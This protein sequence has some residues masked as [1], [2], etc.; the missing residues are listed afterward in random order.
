MFTRWT[1]PKFGSHRSKSVTVASL[2]LVAFVCLTGAVTKTGSRMPRFLLPEIEK[3]G[4]LKAAAEPGA[5]P[6]T[7]W[8]IRHHGECCEGNLAAE[9]P[10]TFLL[11]PILITGNQI[12]KSND[13][14]VNW[15]KKYPP[16]DASVPFGI[17]GD[18][19]AFHD[20]VVFFGTL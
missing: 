4:G 12:W 6:S 16:A 14:G 10:S 3:D 20:D 18:L 2:L 5:S 1:T 15:A 7:H 11:L 17:E 19:N 9:G 13:N 8:I